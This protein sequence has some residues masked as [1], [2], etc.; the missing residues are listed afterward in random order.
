MLG[1]S[2]PW[3]MLLLVPSLAL[4][5]LCSLSEHSLNAQTPS[6][7][8]CRSLVAL[9]ALGR[10]IGGWGEGC[11]TLVLPYFLTVYLAKES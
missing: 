5:P 7:Q 6:R 1:S 4:T 10:R 3:G 2:F 8:I 9:A 11:M